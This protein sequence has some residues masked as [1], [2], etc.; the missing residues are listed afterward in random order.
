[1]EPM[2]AKPS[3]VIKLPDTVG[4]WWKATHGA[5]QSYP[6]SVVLINPL[7]GVCEVQIDGL[8]EHVVVTTTTLPHQR[9]PCEECPEDVALVTQGP[10]EG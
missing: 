6:L 10:S 7:T 2:Y 5:L 1:M 4:A 9:A 8:R 3:R